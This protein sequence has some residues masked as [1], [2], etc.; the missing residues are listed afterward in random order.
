MG[1]AL[2]SHIKIW[3]VGPNPFIANG[4]GI[5]WEL[6]KIR[7]DWSHSCPR[8]GPGWHGWGPSFLEC[9]VPGF[10]QLLRFSV[11]SW[12]GGHP[13]ASESESKYLLWVSGAHPSLVEQAWLGTRL[14][15]KLYQ[16]P[17]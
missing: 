6:V 10:E 2:C 15:F 3:K 1:S 5:P 4:I 17:E 13:L 12:E 11:L 8:L 16:L 9:S 7:G 14:V